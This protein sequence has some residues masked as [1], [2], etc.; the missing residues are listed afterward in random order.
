MGRF[1]IYNKIGLEKCTANSIEYS[2]KWMGESYVSAKI[3]SPE[4]IEFQ[5]GDYIEY[6]GV[7]YTLNYDPSVV[8]QSSKNSIGNAFVYD[9]VKFNGP[10]DDLVRCRF[11]DFVIDEGNQDG[12]NALYHSHTSRFQFFCED[13]YTLAERIQVNLNRLYDNWVVEVVDTSE[14]AHNITINVDNISVWDALGFVSSKFKTS[15]VV[16]QISEDGIRKN[17]ISIGEVVEVENN[18]LRYGKGNGLIKIERSTESSQ[19]LINRLRAYGSERNLPTRYYTDVYD[20]WYKIPCVDVY[21]GNYPSSVDYYFPDDYII[22]NGVLTKEALRGRNFKVR[23]GLDH[24]DAVFSARYVTKDYLQDS[25]Y[26]LKLNNETELR[27]FT[28]K[29]FRANYENIYIVEG[30]TQIDMDA[31]RDSWRSPVPLAPNNMNIKNLMLPNFLDYRAYKQGVLYILPKKETKIIHET[32]EEGAEDKGGNIVKFVWNGDEYLPDYILDEDG[33]HVLDDENNWAIRYNDD[34]Y[35]EDAESIAKYGI[36]EGCVYFESEDEGSET[37]EICPTIKGLTAE[38]ARTSGY[39]I[40]LPKDDNGKLDEL[41]VGGLFAD[42]KEINDDGVP[43]DADEE[44]LPGDFYVTIKDIGF[45]LRDYWSVN[46]PT[47]KMDNGYCGGYE[48]EFVKNY[49]N[50]EKVSFVGD[51]GKEYF[52]YKIHLKRTLD[53]DL[54]LYMPNK[55]NPIKKGDKFVLLEVDLPRTYVDAASSMLETAAREYLEKNSVSKPAYIPTIDRIAMAR[56]YA[57]NGV[58]SLHY[59]LHEGCVLKF[60]D[61]DLGVNVGVDSEKGETR[62][63]IDTLNIKENGIEPPSYTLKLA[64]EQQFSTIQKL[65]NDIAL[66]KAGANT[67]V[68]VSQAKTIAMKMGDD[69]YISKNNNDSAKGVITFEKMPVLKEGFKTSDF[70]KGVVGSATFKKEKNAEEEVDEWCTETDYLTVRKKMYVNEIDIQKVNHIGGSQLMTA[71]RCSVVKVDDYGSFY[72][73]YFLR[74][75]GDGNE[76]S[77]TWAIGDQ[78]YVNTFNIETNADGTKG[79]RRYW[80]VVVGIGENET[81]HWID[82]SNEVV[83]TGEAFAEVSDKRGYE[84]GSSIPL[85]GDDIVQLGNRFGA[86][87]RTSAIELAGAGEGSPYIRQYDDIT[88]FSLGEYDVQIKPGDSLFKGRLEI[89]EGSKGIQ[90]FID[91]PEAVNESVR[92]GGQNL[93][94]NTGFDGVYESTSPSE[95][96]TLDPNSVMYNNQFKYWFVNGDV[97]IVE[98]ENSTSGY[99]CLFG[100]DESFIRQDVVLKENEHYCLSVKSDGN[101]K[102][103]VGGVRVNEDSDDSAYVCRLNGIGGNVSVSFF[104]SAGVHIWDIKLEVGSVFTGWCPSIQDTN[105]VAHQFKELWYLQDTLHNGTTDIL[106]GLILTNMIQ[107]GKFRNNEIGEVTA[108]ISGIMNDGNDIA[109]WAGGDYKK[110]IESMSKVKSGIKLSDIEWKNLIGFAATHGGDM[111]LKGY[112]YALGGVFRGTVYAQDGVFKGTVY[113]NKGEFKG[114]VYAKDGEFHGKVIANEGVFN[115]TINSHDG[116]FSGYLRKKAIEIT[117]DNIEEYLTKDTGNYYYIE[118]KKFG[119]YYRFTGDFKA[120]HFIQIYLPEFNDCKTNEDFEELLRTDFSELIV[121]NEATNTEDSFQVGLVFLEANSDKTQF[122]RTGT[123]KVYK[124]EYLFMKGYKYFGSVQIGDDPLT[125][126]EREVLYWEKVMLRT[127]PNFD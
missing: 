10:S 100:D 58:N 17:Y 52:G 43:R 14:S 95:V 75:D 72:R 116:I 33:N 77:N 105:P 6:R 23:F 117:P 44:Q 65:Q 35:I 46:N 103:F 102:I 106:G 49:Y 78:A 126:E 69:R 16:K 107:C 55:N 48:F 104:G 1:T 12:S 93:L 37:P 18:S 13:V 82:L 20:P 119:P 101:I 71:A 59:K 88:T 60:N 76:I 62:L 80:R 34:P 68:S 90:S 7:Y 67:G 50:P 63:F 127:I 115:G 22:G 73:I 36:R 31:D 110:A 89:S 26:V 38:T 79:N 5:L 25:E 85:V 98:N 39:Q 99:A 11:L 94:L 125:Y 40:T 61:E 112:I 8:K 15:F 120:T 118:A 109:L 42:D 87:G 108:G 66:V 96:F 111:F 24:T 9:N 21:T 51:D 3:E 74:K 122:S 92:V 45:N 70:K 84:L 64:E 83:I 124:G 54:N 57:E 123:A 91:F 86:E 28:E 56:D 113:A 47:I 81:H 19:M 2:G 29:F 32:N 30:L 27:N 41:L 97:N 53:E 121:V 114:T 4:P